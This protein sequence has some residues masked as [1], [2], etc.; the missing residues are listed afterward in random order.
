MYRPNFMSWFNVLL[1][2]QDST[3]RARLM[4]RKEEFRR[5]F[6]GD[7]YPLS[8]PICESAK[9]C[10]CDDVKEYRFEDVDSE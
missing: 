10:T 8:C 4:E 9:N 3:G 5:I 7:V 2:Q 1:A 6:K